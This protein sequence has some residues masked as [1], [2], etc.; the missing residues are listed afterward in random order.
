MSLG[1][2]SGCFSPGESDLGSTWSIK[3]P[4]QASSVYTKVFLPADLRRPALVTYDRGQMTVHDL[5]R[6]AT[7]LQE[8]LAG[9]L[10]GLV[11][12]LPIQN[13]VVNVQRLEVSTSG[14][15]TLLFTANFS[16]TQSQGSTLEVKSSIIHLPSVKV[17]SETNY[18]L[19][20]AF[21]GYVK[22]P[23]CIA[24]QIEER[25]RNEQG[26]IAK[27]STTVTVPTK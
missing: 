10:A 3:A 2:L 24:Q 7:P 16:H 11:A 17:V 15:V 21:G 4:E 9:N 12:H 19:T 14:E 5:E 8:S 27:P 23:D 18:T 25:L 26:V 6:W 13:L 20:A 1:L 22:V